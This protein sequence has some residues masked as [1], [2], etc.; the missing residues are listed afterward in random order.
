MSLYEAN[1]TLIPKQDKNQEQKQKSKTSISDDHRSRYPQHILINEM[2]QY[3]LKY[4][5]CSVSLF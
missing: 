4:I 5:H 3:I 2:Q 1:I